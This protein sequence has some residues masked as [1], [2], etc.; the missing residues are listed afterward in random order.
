MN[1]LE[2]SKNEIDLV[3]ATSGIGS[4]DSPLPP[5]G[6]ANQLNTIGDEIKLP[7]MAI[8][9]TQRFGFNIPEY[10]DQHGYEATKEK[11]ISI[12]PISE[13]MPWEKIDYKSPLVHPVD[14]NDYFK[15]N[16]EY[17]P[18]IGN[19]LVYFDGSHITNTY[20]KTM[21]P[22]LREDVIELLD[23]YSS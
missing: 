20:S 9:D 13:T 10:L 17:E 5:E 3:V 22:V 18:V 16:G 11:L 21:G 14:Y 23:K 12:E 19:V 1:Y 15:V 6:M 7:V 8:R 2:D 4:V